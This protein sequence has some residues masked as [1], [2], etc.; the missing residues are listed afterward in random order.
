MMSLQNFDGNLKR[1]SLNGFGKSWHESDSQT[2]VRFQ[3]LWIS[4]YYKRCNKKLKALSPLFFIIFLFFSPRES[5]LKTL[6]NV[7]YFI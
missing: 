1:L 4:F 7:F 6:K 5:P 2:R 3:S